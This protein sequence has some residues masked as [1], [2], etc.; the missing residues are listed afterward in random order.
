LT[1]LNVKVKTK[2]LPEE[3]F[4]SLGY[5]DFNKQDIKER[6]DKHLFV[7]QKTPL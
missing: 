6:C 5:T 4:A 3:N 1:D 2:N 7:L